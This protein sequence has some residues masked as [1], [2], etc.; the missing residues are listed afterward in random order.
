MNFL[1]TESGR[2][3]AYSLSEGKGPGV[4]FL[5]G[6]MSDMTGTKAHS[7]QAWCE[8]KKM[9]FLR[10]D[11]SGHGS[12]SGFFTDGCIGDWAD[13]ALATIVKL[14]KGPQ[15][16][17]G[18]SMGGWIALLLA[19]RIPDKIFGLVTV[20]A[21]PD[22]TEDGIWANFDNQ[23]RKCL[24]EEGIVSVPSDYGSPYPITKRLIEDG[25]T[26]LVL[27]TPLRLPFPVRLLQGDQDKDV[28]VELA[29]QL[30]QHI[31]GSDVCLTLLKGADHSFSR[32]DA[33]A[34]LKTSILDIMRFTENAGC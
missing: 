5:G 20:A 17:V 14:T 8:E 2:L 12:S 18:S 6:F 33:I 31:E 11:Y 19:Q 32:P 10:F 16:L 34:L 21:A 1:K 22:F 25:R 29:N 27:R 3:I 7:L 24:L 28:S 15:I 9:P 4:V 23:T 30:F 13:D 26:H